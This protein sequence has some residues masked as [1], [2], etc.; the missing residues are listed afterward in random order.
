MGYLNSTFH[1]VIK[2]FV[3]QGGDFVNHDGTKSWT[4]GGLLT[5]DMMS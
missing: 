2:G 4:I 3:L 1:R 5:D